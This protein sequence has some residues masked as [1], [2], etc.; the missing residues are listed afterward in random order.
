MADNKSTRS[1]EEWADW[2][3]RNWRSWGSW[4]SWGS[5]TGLA[6]FFIGC[7]LTFWIVMQAIK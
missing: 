5:P 1:S 6:L 4:W 7:A 2:S 3:A